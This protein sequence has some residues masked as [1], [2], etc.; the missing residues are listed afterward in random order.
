MATV[1]ELKNAGLL[2]VEKLAEM[3]EI[4][5]A[6]RDIETLGKHTEG[7]LSMLTEDLLSKHGLY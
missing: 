6:Y 7:L 4:C 1:E 2:T 5:A 3:E